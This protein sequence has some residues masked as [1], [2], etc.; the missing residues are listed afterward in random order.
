[1]S[2]NTY[3]CSDVKT[4]RQLDRQSD[5]YKA[6]YFLWK[7]WYVLLLSITCFVF[8]YRHLLFH[9]IQYITEFAGYRISSSQ[10]EGKGYYYQVLYDSGKVCVCEWMYVREKF[11][12]VYDPWVMRVLLLVFAFGYSVLPH[13]LLTS[14]GIQGMWLVWWFF[15]LFILFYFILFYFI[16]SLPVSH[17]VMIIYH[18]SHKC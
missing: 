8:F 12:E 18:K 9:E 16:L 6:M 13:F 3:T 1:M 15:L 14:S 7:L 17:F 4:T 2:T 5:W 10:T 11:I